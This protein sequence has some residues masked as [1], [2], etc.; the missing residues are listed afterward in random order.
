MTSQNNR[1]LV[2]CYVIIMLC[3]LFHS[4]QWIWTEEQCGKAQFGS[5]SAIFL[6]RTN[7]KFDRWPWKTK[8]HLFYATSSFVYHF[9]DNGMYI[10]D[11]TKTTSCEREFVW[12][13]IVTKHWANCFSF[14]FP[15]GIMWGLFYQERLA[16]PTRLWHW[17]VITAINYGIE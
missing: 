16:K 15:L 5:K 3:A 6:S 12:I 10:S 14:I 13:F 4:H 1:A 9:I 7:F 11:I 2:L 8:G 17:V